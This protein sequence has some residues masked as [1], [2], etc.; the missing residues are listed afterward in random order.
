M[1]T[2]QSGGPFNT[3]G[4][5]QWPVSIM[6][7]GS[8]LLEPSAIDERAGYKTCDPDGPRLHGGEGSPRYCETLTGSKDFHVHQGDGPTI[9][10]G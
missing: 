3:T 5:E 9:G 1:A 6:V 8:V 10:G 7:T 4:T 2:T